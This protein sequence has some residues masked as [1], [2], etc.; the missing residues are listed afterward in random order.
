MLERFREYEP[1]IAAVLGV[2]YC[3]VCQTNGQSL[4]LE[5]DERFTAPVVAAALARRGLEV[6]GVRPGDGVTDWH[7]DVAEEGRGGP[8]RYLLWCAYGRPDRVQSLVV[9]G[10]RDRPLIGIGADRR[11]WSRAW[12]HRDHSPLSG[13]LRVTE[14][15]AER[16]ARVLGTSLPSP[17][18]VLTLLAE[19]ADRPDAAQGL[20]YLP[21][22]RAEMGA[23]YWTICGLRFG[24]TGDDHALVQDDEP[25]TEDVVARRLRAM[26]LEPLTV[27]WAAGRWVAD[28]ASPVPRHGL[29]HY[30][31][32]G[33]RAH[34]D[35]IRSLIPRVDHE[36]LYYRKDS[37]RWERWSG[38]IPGA[39][40]SPHHLDDINDDESEIMLIGREQAERVARALD[41]EL[42][43][44][45]ELVAVAGRLRAGEPAP[46]LPLR[47]RELS[48][49]FQA[50]VGA[51][52]C[53]TV[54]VPVPP[55]SRREEWAQAA[56]LLFGD[57]PFTPSL[58]AD[59]LTG[60]GLRVVSVRPCDWPPGDWWAELDGEPRCWDER[61]DAVCR[62]GEYDR[63][64]YLE[65]RLPDVGVHLGC[66]PEDG[67]WGPLGWTAGLPRGWWARTE[68]RDWAPHPPDEESRL[69]VTRE[70]AERLARAL[71]TT[72]PAGER[73]EELV[74]VAATALDG[75]QC[76]EYSPAL[77]EVFGVG[78]WS[79]CTLSQ[80]GEP[81]LRALVLGEEPLDAVTV[82]EQLRDIGVEATGLTW[83]RDPEVSEWRGELVADTSEDAFSYYTH[84]L[85]PSGD[86]GEILVLK[87]DVKMW[88]DPSLARWNRSDPR[89]MAGS[90]LVSR[91]SAERLARRRGGR[92]P[93]EDEFVALTS[94]YVPPRS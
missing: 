91:R 4:L 13:R 62:R 44:D 18:E 48:P 15:Q 11:R 10:E 32:R 50:A 16:W 34:A 56:A 51:R 88:Y 85:R 19:D 68:N 74:Q 52:Y 5:G 78:Y 69:L 29:R 79:L 30:V 26:G 45:D 82:A 83:H 75:L 47:Y 7:A 9:M 49:R 65:R 94:M 6:T 37:G 2:R 35:E 55:G 93:G 38:L 43:G 81:A 21:A 80:H 46:S 86:L 14:D 3:T 90:V 31:R 61:L 89:N 53:T 59:T 27:E 40:R 41:I 20:E 17:A 70:Q 72:L 71:G 57:R 73:W 23:R 54:R 58:V 67:S 60:M 8:G 84:N 77:R 36:Q 87:G 66:D 12:W 22:R 76:S 39:G 25:L 63:V 64:R 33:K 92:L 1:H 42:P 28:L 24:R